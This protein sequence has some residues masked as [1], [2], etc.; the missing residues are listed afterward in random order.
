MS[1]VSL[2]GGGKKKADPP[3]NLLPAG[4]GRKPLGFLKRFRSLRNPLSPPPCREGWV[5]PMQGGWHLRQQLPN[6]SS[7]R[8][9]TSRSPTPGIRSSITCR[10]AF[11]LGSGGPCSGRMVPANLHFG[12]CS[13]A[14]I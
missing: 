11:V 7:S 5:L 2:Q 14:I 8:F 9:A 12:A 3:P 4:R 6:P 1:C 10:G 13:A